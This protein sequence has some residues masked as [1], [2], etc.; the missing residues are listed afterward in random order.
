MEKL[1]CDNR[2]IKVEVTKE[3]PGRSPL[4]VWAI[5]KAALW[6]G[7]VDRALAFAAEISR[8]DYEEIFQII[9]SHIQDYL[10]GMGTMTLSSRND[11]AAKYETTH[12]NGG[13]TYSFPVFFIKDED[14]NWRIFRF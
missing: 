12:E 9:E 10:T 13:Q 5:F 11:D 3:R 6:V 4:H 8:Q 14:G 7:D 1:Q 2:I